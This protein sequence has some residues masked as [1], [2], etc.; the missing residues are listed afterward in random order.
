[1]IVCSHFNVFL[2]VKC[3]FYLLLKK[4]MIYGNW[5]VKPIFKYFD[6]RLSNFKKGNEKLENQGYDR[7]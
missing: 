4:F 2:A 5:T 3:Q 7:L 6:T 1:M